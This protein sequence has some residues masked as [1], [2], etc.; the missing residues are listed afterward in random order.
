M[1]TYLS[2]EDGAGVGVDPEVA[3]GEGAV[4]LEE[5]AVGVADEV[6]ADGGDG[7]GPSRSA[8]EGR[9]GI[10]GIE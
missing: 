8:S 3:A 7:G 6:H 2:I 1:H 9:E 5:K 10:I 4:V